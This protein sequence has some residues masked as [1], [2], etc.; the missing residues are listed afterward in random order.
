V[1]YPA[2]GAPDI[3]ERVL[4]LLQAQ[5]IPARADARR[6]YDH[7]VFVPMA[8]MYQAAD[9][10]L[11]QV[12]TLKSYDPAAHFALGRALA[13]LRCEGV[14]IIGSGL[15]YHNLRQIGP[16]AKVPSAAFDA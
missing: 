5:G 14:M 13:E 12:S 7:G 4:G 1:V 3:A 10:P 9:V 2:P 8:V 6:G 11:F 16:Q 15:S